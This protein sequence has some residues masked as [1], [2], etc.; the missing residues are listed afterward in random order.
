MMRI[1]IINCNQSIGKNSKYLIFNTIISSIWLMKLF[2]HFVKIY[3]DFQPSGSYSQV[4]KEYDTI[5]QNYEE[6]RY[7]IE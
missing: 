5:R 6:N 7:G 4:G 1:R 2:L 3:I